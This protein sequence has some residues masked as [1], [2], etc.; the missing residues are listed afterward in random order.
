MSYPFSK[1][2][3]LFIVK[4]RVIQSGLSYQMLTINLFKSKA[5]KSR[6]IR[7]FNLTHP[8]KHSSSKLMM[9]APP[10][11]P[12]VPLLWNRIAS[13]CDF[14]KFSIVYGDIPCQSHRQSEQ[15]FTIPSKPVCLQEC[16]TNKNVTIPSI[17]NS[18]INQNNTCG[19]KLFSL[20][21]VYLISSE[22]SSVAGNT[23]LSWHVDTEFILQLLEIIYGSIIYIYQISLE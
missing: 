23:N 13:W 9:G 10:I 7:S 3:T 5:C 4:V 22:D 14:P 16:A 20:P 12:V 2:A 19:I 15:K 21:I 6:F 8:R 1:W 17:Y 18:H 11:L